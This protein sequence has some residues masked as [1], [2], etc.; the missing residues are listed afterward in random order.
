MYCSGPLRA[1]NQPDITQFVENA[2]N[3]RNFN[4]YLPN[5]SESRIISATQNSN[6]ECEY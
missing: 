2:S 3:H 1:D 6:I 5:N 4:T